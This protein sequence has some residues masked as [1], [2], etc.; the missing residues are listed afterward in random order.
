MIGV[1]LKGLAGRKLR[2]MLTAFA[3]VLGVAMI[4]GTYVL[5]DTID[6]A[7]K[8]VFTQAYAGTDVVVTGK[9]AFETDFGVP[10]PF[11][12]GLLDEV[13]AQPGVDAAVGGIT[14]L[15][16]LTDKKGDLISTMGA[17]ALA[18][19]IDT[20]EERFN[21]LKL[22]EG[23]WPG[24]P[25]QVVI[26]A[27]TADQEGYEVG[28][29][30]G[31]A[32]KGPV[33]RF[34]ISGIAQFG[35]VDS[36]GSA[37]FAVFDVPT[38]QALFHKEGKLDGIQVAAADGVAPEELVSEIRPILPAGTEVQTGAQE[39]QDATK[40][41]EGFTKF[42]RYFLLA[43]GGIALFVG[44]FVIFTTLSIT[45]AQRVREF[46]TL[47]TI[48]ASRRQ[49][50]G[51]VILEAVVIGLAA[52]VVGLFLGLGL[53]KGLN[54]ILVSFGL[55]LPT[56]GAVFAS[57]TVIVSLLAGVL[58]T[59]VAGIVPAVRA[60]R[61]PP[62][63]AVREGA[64][65]PRS[66]YARFAPYAAALT[67]ALGL[68]L[69]LYGMF[70]GDMG[71]GQRLGSL[72]AGCLI[73]FVGVAGFSSRLVR[74]LASVLGWPALRIGG[75]AGRLARE[76]SMRNPHRTA[77]TAA[78]LMI[79]LALI[80]FVAVLAQGLR[81]SIGDAVNRQVNADYVVVS[82]DGFTPFEPAADDALA[83][84]AG[85]EV[86]G[87][88]ADR[89]RANGKEEN[90]TGVDPATI[91]SVYEF[92]WVDGSDAVL[93]GLGEDGAIVE[94]TFAEDETLSIGS[95]L[96]LET[97]NGKSLTLEV[98]GI[99]EAP[100][101]W[102]MLGNVSI[103]AAAFDAAF[104]DPRNLYTFI[105]T[106]GGATPGNEQTLEQA[107]QDF[108]GVKLDTKDGFSK[109]QQDSIGP[110]LN[111]LY[112]LLALS[113]IVSLFGIVNTLV[114]S[115]FERTRELGMLRAVG[116]TRRQVRRMIRHESV[117]TAMIGAVLGMALGIFLAV[118]VTQALKD[119]G[120]VF[121][122][123]VGNLAVFAGVAVV[124]GMLAA[125][126]PARRAARLNVL[127]ALQYE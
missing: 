25:G 13:R 124:A 19:G 51:S 106:P 67:A 121:S 47:R 7:F 56:T 31:V 39:V 63:A 57:R 81:D 32:A 60:T 110:L 116:M 46:A 17:P 79:G 37:T 97:P 100:P 108:P 127:E 35:S 41:I 77:A 26:D 73:L 43:F 52:S 102:E 89:A 99:Y 55:D 28:D 1:S 80:T 120:V 6:R 59:L 104:Q 101:F 4:S 105:S 85:A 86:V 126:F 118:L 69:L 34:T 114:L 122:V 58:I 27:G 10:P 11:D 72:G 22:T 117:I 21:A 3:I 109:S 76:N 54:S 88:R 78:A 74:P 68:A 95:R 44:A 94:R 91:A 14:D 5:T 65:L 103:P 2:A 48:G 38:A 90:V 49:V 70:V 96:V 12:E 33:Q 113:V 36:L 115:V 93:A 75:A 45:V 20:S 50:L 123:P 66:R 82:E 23:S 84:V 18:F 87:V 112:V 24:G 40:D 83:V 71:I 98:R 61:V 15:A 30:I 62:I 119:E 111:L 42:I 125:I 92:D 107:L 16:Q 29:A 9:E 53:A 64:T 8:D